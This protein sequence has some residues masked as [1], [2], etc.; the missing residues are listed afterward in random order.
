M[1]HVKYLFMDILK[2]AGIG[3]AISLAIAIITGLLAI[4]FSWGNIPLSMEW[5]KRVVYFIGG[6]G[7]FLSAGAFIQREGTRPFVYNEEWKAHFKIFNFGFV[8]MLISFS[9][10]VCGMIVQN[11]LEFGIIF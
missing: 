7:L 4:L 10:I 3:V 8:V 9:V 2:C 11:L 1:K 6:L 5:I